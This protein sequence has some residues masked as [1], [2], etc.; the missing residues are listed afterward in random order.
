MAIVLRSG[1]VRLV[2]SQMLLSKAPAKH[3]PSLQQAACISS[4][5]Y[6]DLNGIK[7]PPP[8]NYIETPYGYWR[9]LLDRTTQRLDENSKVGNHCQ[10]KFV[11]II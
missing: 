1:M 10:P 7:R 3:L 8:Y 9:S 6:R 4:K 2:P 5:A 11:R